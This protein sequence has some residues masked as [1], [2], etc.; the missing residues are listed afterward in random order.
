MADDGKIVAKMLM[1]AANRFHDILK[2]RQWFTSDRF[3]V[4]PM[5]GVK[6]VKKA[7]TQVTKTVVM[8]LWMFIPPKCDI[9]MRFCSF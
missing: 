5:A 6:G 7:T 1:D 2:I 8:E 9:S 4:H 3:F